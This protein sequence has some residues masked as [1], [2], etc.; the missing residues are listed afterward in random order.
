MS[1]KTRFVEI[2]R[3]LVTLILVSVFLL[4]PQ[5]KVKAETLTTI[6]DQL[7]RVSNNTK[8]SHTIYFVTSNAV[9]ASGNIQITFPGSSFSFGSSYD[10]N[11]MVLAQGNSSNC[12]TATYTNK[13][14]AAVPAGSTWGATY[15]S[16]VVT[17]TSGTGTLTA[18]SCIKAILNTNSTNHDITNPNVTSNTVYNISVNTSVGDSGQLAVIILGDASATNNDQITLH[19]N[20][21]TSILLG[22]DVVSTDCNNATQTTPANQFINFGILFPSVAKYSTSTTYPFVCISAGTNAPTGM[23]IL[24]QSSRNNALG[25]LLGPSDVIPSA[26]PNLNLSGTLDG[27]GIRVASTGTPP[28]GRFVA[29]A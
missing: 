2:V 26:T 16:N 20:I 25:G 7:S 28:A 1:V 6:S 5:I 23:Q 24:V 11:D 3:L 12:L 19:A 17:F 29:I 22:I 21:E 8:A 10:F 14:L 4:L 18:N 15:S 9:I 13:T 27:Y